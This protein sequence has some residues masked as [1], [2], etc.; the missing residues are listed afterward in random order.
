MIR[1]ALEYFLE[2]PKVG[3]KQ[4]II[5]KTLLPKHSKTENIGIF[6]FIILMHFRFH[7]S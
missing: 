4:T 6:I 1:G 7:Y 2:I 3:T 5:S